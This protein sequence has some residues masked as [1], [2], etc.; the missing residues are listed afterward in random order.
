MVYRT[1]LVANLEVCII[2]L[3]RL[4]MICQKLGGASHSENAPVISGISP[5]AYGI[6]WF[7][8]VCI[9]T[10]NHLQSGMYIRNIAMDQ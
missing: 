5:I 8:Y 7:I 9:W 4:M 6:I 3:S 10:K 2:A 1:H